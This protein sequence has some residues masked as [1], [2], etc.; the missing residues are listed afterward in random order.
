MA[1]PQ[2][3]T[4][5]LVG[6]PNVGKSRL[7]NR[8]ARRRVAIVHDLAGVTRDVNALE[9]DDCYTLLDTGGIGL[10]V[11]MDHQKLISA[12]EEQVWFAIEAAQLICFVVDA[13]EGLTPLDQTLAERLRSSGKEVLLIINKAD[14]SLLEERAL[15]DFAALGFRRMLP[16]SAEHGRNEDAV[17]SIIEQS[18]DRIIP[19]DP[20]IE[21]DTPP[22]RIPLAFVG[23][24]NVGKSS[25]VNRLL[26]HDRLVVSE[27]P[28]TTRDSVSLDLDFTSKDGETWPFRLIDTAGLR[29]RGKV[30]HSVE[31]FSS[32]R[33]HHA[34]E[35][36]GIVFLVIDAEAGVTRA[37]KTLAGEI[38]E[39]GRCLVIVVNKWD[40]ALE[41]FQREPVKG[42]E[43]V[44]E[45]RA[46]YEE[47]VRKEL[48]F[49][50]DSPIVFISAKTGYSFDRV[51]RAARLLWET[52]SRTIPT[53]R[54][55]ALFTKLVDARSPKLVK[56]RRF[57]LYY[58]TQTGNR[59]F[60]FRLF[61]NRAT[62][63]DDPYRRY[64]QKS[65]TETFKL[66]GCPIRFDLRGKTVRYAGSAPGGAARDPDAPRPKAATKKGVKKSARPGGRRG[67][68][69]GS[70]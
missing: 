38:I 70:R 33:S 51:L 21:G 36:A 26:N 57:K 24:P 65:I 4:V 20:P 40:V 32:V 58:A 22:P 7:F 42:Y 59:P 3:R 60:V 16:I 31:Y 23:R 13:R 62:K 44:D 69:R 55:N 1:P 29:N 54:L 2:Q 43:T 9:I 12:A 25:I 18:L 45:F 47:S 8:L 61:C 67:R 63:L 68:S 14:D 34:I 6:R 49:L 10:V 53:A 39:A 66:T 48:F 27:V 46:A 35:E 37:D 5:A 11:D 28:G 56:G 52:S 17:R 41:Q 50:P 64:L 30:S 19:L 15:N